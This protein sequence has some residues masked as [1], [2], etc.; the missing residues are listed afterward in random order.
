M[1]AF[2]IVLCVYGQ[3]KDDIRGIMWAMRP[4]MAFTNLMQSDH[5]HMCLKV[6]KY[7]D[8]SKTE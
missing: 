6:R 8:I 3:G 5:N 7:L 4:P 2:S 1:R